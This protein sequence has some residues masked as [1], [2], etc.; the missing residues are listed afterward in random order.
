MEGSALVMAHC[1]NSF[2]APPAP[3]RLQR[4][5]ITPQRISPYLSHFSFPFSI[6]PPKIAHF[7]ENACNISMH[8]T[9]GLIYQFEN[10]ISI[11]SGGC[12]VSNVD[13]AA[14]YCVRKERKHR[15]QEKRFR[16][17]RGGTGENPLRRVR[18]F[19]QEHD[20]FALGLPWK[21]RPGDLPLSSASC[22]PKSPP[23]SASFTAFSCLHTPFPARLLKKSLALGSHKGVEEHG[24]GLGETERTLEKTVFL[25]RLIHSQKSLRRAGGG[26]G[27][28]QNKGSFSGFT[29]KLSRKTGKGW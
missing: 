2:S 15:K 29:G 22:L 20:A 10:T 6:Q 17:P 12:G 25:A 26:R 16:I 19:D 3:Y 21:S 9:Q 27:S 4:I 1:F 23:T 7:S 8:G 13:F 11:L 18:Q 14:G 24:M 28:E 5:I